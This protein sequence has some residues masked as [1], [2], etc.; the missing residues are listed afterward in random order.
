MELQEYILYVPE[1]NN[2]SD[3]ICS[4]IDKLFGGGGTA[5]GQMYVAIIYT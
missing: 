4:I 1:S 5:T 3:I 2:H